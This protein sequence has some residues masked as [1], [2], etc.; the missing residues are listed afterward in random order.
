MGLVGYAMYYSASLGEAL[1]RLARYGRILNEA[2]QYVLEEID[3]ATS[4]SCHVHP[5][6][7]ALR[8]P[9]E[10]GAAAIVSIAR[11]ITASELVPLGID[12]PTSKPD[13]L[14]YYR[15]VFSC[16]IRF[17]RPDAAIQFSSRQ[18]QLPTAAADPTLTG[19]LDDL[20]TMKLDELGEDGRDLVD[21]VRQELWA[22]L[23][24]G[25]PD[26]WRTASEI[27]ISARTL[28]RRLGEQGTSFSKVLDD[29]RRELS[30]EL[31]A[32]RKLAVS[33]VAFL[34]GYSEPSAFQ[35]AFRRWRGVSPRRFRTG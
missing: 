2:V 26:L 15:T 1:N 33:E 29:L 7:V 32:D 6:L 17:D 25:R 31:L 12:F 30:D 5:S 28:Q 22:M 27:G 34:L 19:Y 11:E 20:A 4:L 9:I 3:D 18:M 21:R 35:R 24:G 10:A 13:S 16:P 23:P 8:H 14:S